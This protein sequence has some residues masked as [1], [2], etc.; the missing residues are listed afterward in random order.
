MIKEIFIIDLKENNE[1]YHKRI[2]NSYDENH[3]LIDVRAFFRPIL[4]IISKSR[5]YGIE[6]INFAVNRVS[7]VVEKNIAFMV[8]SYRSTTDNTVTKYILTR[9]K[10]VFFKKI[11]YKKILQTPNLSKI[12][13]E[14]VNK[15]LNDFPLK[16]LIL[17]N[18]Y[19]RAL[20]ILAL[21]KG[22]DPSYT[23]NFNN[24]ILAPRG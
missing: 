23:Y 6:H 19:Q 13:E 4:K 7:F 9:L 15:I 3:N 10:E 18:D 8:F 14:E 24:L 20:N 12:L 11:N 5:G 22:L 21:I 16:M 2:S 17:S 1:I